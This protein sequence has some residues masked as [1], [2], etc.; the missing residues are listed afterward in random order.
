MRIAVLVLAVSM[1]AALALGA[2]QTIHAAEAPAKVVLIAGPPSHG[3]GDHE[4]L[5][6]LRLLA[7]CLREIGGVEPL[8]VDLKGGWPEEKVF[9]GARAIA[10]FS[11]GGG[12]HPLLRKDDK[13]GKRPVDV[14]QKH[15]EKGVGL[16]FIHYTVEFPKGEDGERAL[17]WLG[18]YYE[19]GHSTNPMNTVV[20]KPASP[21][22][23]ISRGLE[24]YEATDEFYYRIRFRPDD[25]RVTPIL[26]MVPKEPGQGVQTIAW[27]TERKDGGRSF[28]FTGGHFHRNWGLPGFRRMVLNALLWAAKLEVPEGGAKSTVTEEDLKRDLDKK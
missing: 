27:A 14:L 28:G 5:A 17:D 23:P 26:T 18:G 13:T 21:S 1:G 22:H 19:P 24:A 20:V 6:G 15:V 25:K 2:T 16:V 9:E 3:P 4:H 10:M 8:V 11:D 7:K 12:G